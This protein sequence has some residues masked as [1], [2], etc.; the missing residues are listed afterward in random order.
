MIS[1]RGIKKEIEFYE[2]MKADHERRIDK[3]PKGTLLY[4]MEHGAKRPYHKIDGKEQ[5]INLKRIGLVRDLEVRRELEEING[6]ITSNIRL[7]RYMLDHYIEIERFGC[8]E[9]GNN[10]AGSSAECLTRKEKR[11]LLTEWSSGRGGNPNYHEGKHVTSDGTKVKSR[12]EL[13]FYEYLKMKGVVFRY[14]APVMID[15]QVWYP[16]FT[17]IRESDGAVILWDHFGMM[18]DEGYRRTAEYK[19]AKYISEGYLPFVNLITTF[20]F[21]GD[22]IDLSMVDEILRMMNIVE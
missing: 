9:Q 10:L 18:D 22:D 5:Y 19:I 13:A 7:L 11:R 3:L 20:D 1:K 21:G 14:E 15:G 16:D 2:R 12:A 6:D 4:K 8:T 17:I